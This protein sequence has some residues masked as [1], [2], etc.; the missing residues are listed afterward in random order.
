MNNGT[1]VQLVTD[2]SLPDKHFVREAAI[3]LLARDVLLGHDSESAENAIAWARYFVDGWEN[4][5]HDGD[6]IKRA[7]TCSRCMIDE[8]KREAQEVHDD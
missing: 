4:S 1:R 5:E 6:C 3:A 8:A 2:S 7:H